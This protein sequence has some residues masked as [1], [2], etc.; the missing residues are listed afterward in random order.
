MLMCSCTTSHSENNLLHIRQHM[1]FFSLF[2]YL[3]VF[4]VA[5]VIMILLPYFTGRMPHSGKLPVLNLL[6][7][8]KSAFSPHRGTAKGRVLSRIQSQGGVTQK[9]GSLPSPRPHSQSPSP[10]LPAPPLPLEVGPLKT[11]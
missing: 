9:Q 2:A 3:F 7:G 1:F 5:D 11:S 10:P 6:R 4:A 8:Q